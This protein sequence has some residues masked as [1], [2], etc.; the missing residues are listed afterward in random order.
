M[1]VIVVC[2]LTRCSS[3]MVCFYLQCW[4]TYVGSAFYKLL[5]MDFFIDVGITLGVEL[6]RK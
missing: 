5:V 3:N 2:A 6:P 1:Y 4:E